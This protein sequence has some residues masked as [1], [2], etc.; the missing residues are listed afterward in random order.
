M[1]NLQ[2]KPLISLAGAFY[3]RGV[4]KD[5]KGSFAQRALNRQKSS[6]A[7]FFSTARL[8]KLSL[9]CL[10]TALLALPHCKNDDNGG[11]G[12]DPL[13]AV[14][15]AIYLWVADCTVQGNMNGGT[16]LAP[17]DAPTN[18]PERADAICAN[19]Y[20]SDVDETSRNRIAEEGE[21]RHTAMLAR[22]NDLPKEVF[23][24]R[25]K[26]T[27]EIKRPD[28]TTL[29]ADSWNDFF[30][31][32]KTSLESITSSSGANYWTGW[33]NDYAGNFS[34]ATSMGDRRY[35]GGSADSYWTVNTGGGAVTS[36]GG[37]GQ[38]NV[39]SADRL[40]DHVGTACSTPLN[41]LCIT[42]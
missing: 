32:D 16:C 9:A 34:P 27:L 20:E 22:S 8:S 38:G 29:I 4:S 1:K 35:C 36:T 5:A 33:W 12:G 31:Y 25:G 23:P 41:I 10:L 6:P 3:L 26:D 24:V 39:P 2:I 28:G 40:I 7:G 13:A 21:P 19:Q 37:R 18:G 11:G 42:H 15:N 14:L 17:A 30:T